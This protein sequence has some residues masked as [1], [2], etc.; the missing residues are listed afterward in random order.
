M[1]LAERALREY[2]AGRPQGAADAIN[3][4]CEETGSTGLSIAV[5][6][7]IDTVTARLRLA[8]RAERTA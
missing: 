8:T 6:A 5:C 3:A 2:M 7:W 1:Q 4:I